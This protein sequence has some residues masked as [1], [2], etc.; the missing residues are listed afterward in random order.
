[1]GSTIPERCDGPKYGKGAARLPSKSKI[2]DRYFIGKPS[3][4]INTATSGSRGRREEM[5]KLVPLILPVGQPQRPRP[6]LPEQYGQLVL[7]LRQAN[8][9]FGV[10]SA[11]VDRFA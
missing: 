3:P 11:K 2:A 5:L 10:T 1:M 6:T 8:A 4:I 7:F 9:V